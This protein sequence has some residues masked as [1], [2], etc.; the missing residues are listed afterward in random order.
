MSSLLA[1]G[2]FTQAD[3]NKD[4]KLSQAEFTALGGVWFDKL[5]ARKGGALTQEQFSEGLDDVL[6][7]ISFGG[8]GGGGFGGGRGP[9]GQRGG[10]E[11]MA[12]GIGR[13]VAPGLFSGFD[14]DTNGS[15]TRVEMTG[16][17]ASWY[18]GIDTNKTDALTSRQ[19][20][21]GFP[22][23]MPR[24][25]L[26]GGR[27]GFGGPGG[28]GGPG[29]GFGGMGMFSRRDL[30]AQMVSQ[31][32]QDKNSALSKPELV[33]VMEIWFDKMDTAKSGKLSQEQFIEKLGD[34]QGGGSG[35]GRAFGPGLFAAT[36]AD[37]DG[38]VTRVE[39][40]GSFEKW[41]A[42]WDTEKSG[43]LNSEALYAGLREVMPQQGFGGFGGGGGAGP[44]QGGQR[45][46]GGGRGPGGGGGGFGGGDG[47]APARP[48]TAEQ[49][50]LV[51]AWID[52]GAK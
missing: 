48:L 41:F 26:G 35:A 32:D 20:S 14:R 7:E 19:F 4:Q 34:V 2:L 42:E 39:F 12:F 49:V 24:S 31:G 30:A 50:G 28:P 25:N 46:V 11:G 22:S 18:A 44:G 51:R 38:S 17:F 6:P 23:A 9:G 37:K 52:Q 21:E 33:A 1:G 29:G 3:S 8:G 10:N 13:F 15:L 27:G 43:A 40:K 45:G 5:D 36:D 16:T 47:G